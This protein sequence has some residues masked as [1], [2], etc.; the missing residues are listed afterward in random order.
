VRPRALAL[1]LA[2]ALLLGSCTVVGDPTPQLIPLLLRV[3]PPDPP[4]QVACPDALLGDVRL[5]VDPGRRE[6]IVAVAAGGERV[7][8]VFRAGTQAV[9]DT[10]TGVVHQRSP[11]GRQ[12]AVGPERT[13]SFGGGFTFPGE[14]D[15][16]FA[17]SFV[18]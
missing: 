14:D 10:T 17:C 12:L 7:R 8:L 11:E 6:P 18:D 2:P 15:V 5:E 16:F 9:F 4:G 13:V 1:V 3:T